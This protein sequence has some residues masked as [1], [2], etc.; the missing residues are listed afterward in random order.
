MALL[1][2]PSPIKNRKES[3]IDQIF[4]FLNEREHHKPK[5]KCSPFKKSIIYQEADL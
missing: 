4:S 3:G 5:S 1:L 2:S